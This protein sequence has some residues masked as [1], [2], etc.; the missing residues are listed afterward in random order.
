MRRGTLAKSARKIDQRSILD[1][2]EDRRA[3]NEKESIA[4]S[5]AN[6]HL[7]NGD[8]SVRLGLHNDGQG[9]SEVDDVESS[10]LGQ[11]SINATEVKQN[12][13]GQ[14]FNGLQ[15]NAN[16]P[17]SNNE[18]ALLNPRDAVMASPTI[19]RYSEAVA[20]HAN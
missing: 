3:M 8:N 10:Y 17:L 14:R 16:F 11:Y 18:M 7:A 6:R 20:P 15:F 1:N 5:V 12:L 4:A 19:S 13:R 2:E 9:D